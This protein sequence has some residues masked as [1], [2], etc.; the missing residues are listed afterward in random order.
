MLVRRV[1]LGHPVREVDAC[2]APLVEDVRVC[3]AAGQRERRPVTRAGQ[4]P[5]GERDRPIVAAEAV[6]AVA[7][8]DLRLHFALLHARGEGEGVEHLLHTSASLRSSW[9]RASAATVHHSGTMLRAV[10]PSILPTFAVVSSSRRPSR[11]SAIARAAA[12]AGRPSSDTCRRARRAV[13]APEERGRRR[14]ARTT[15]PIGAAWSNTYPTEARSRVWSNAGAE[16]ADLLLRRE[17][18]LDARVPTTLGDDPA[19]RLEHDRDGRLV[20]GAEDRSAGVSD[21][22]LLRQARS[23]PRA[24]TVSRC[25]HRNGGTPP[26]FV[27]CGSTRRRDCR[28]TSRPERRPRPP[29]H[30]AQ[31][32]AGTRRP[33]RRRPFLARRARN[34]RQF[35]EEVESGLDRFRNLCEVATFPA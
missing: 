7:R 33:R 25:A 23:A 5:C 28:S 30:R 17:H 34:R 6:A 19:D 29:R 35:G 11:R 22:V 24:G 16:E 32:L 12:I 20:V 18:G 4:R 21:D 26:P 15:S 10:P 31:G 9:E 8:L 14:R 27:P 13:E 1:D 2:Q 3:S